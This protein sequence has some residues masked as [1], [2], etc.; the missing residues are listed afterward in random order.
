MRLLLQQN[1]AERGW[2]AAP[3]KFQIKERHEPMSCGS[4]QVFGC[5]DAQLNDSLDH[6][7]RRSCSTR[8]YTPVTWVSAHR[9]TV[10]LKQISLNPS[11]QKSS[12]AFR[13]GAVMLLFM[14][15][16]PAMS[17]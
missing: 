15:L 13:V 7:E 1:E 6:F 2:P 3:E 12:L 11:S 16:S 5:F 14:P 9:E 10:L 8:T 17:T 4:G